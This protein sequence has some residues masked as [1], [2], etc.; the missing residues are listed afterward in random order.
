MIQLLIADDHQVLLDGFVSIF[1]AVDQIKVVDTATNGREVLEKLHG[2]EV[3]IA[4]LDINM[5]ELNGVETCK[6]ISRR[7]ADTKVIALSMYDNP[8]YVKR[9]IKHGAMGY[10]LKND[11]AQEIIKAIETV[12]EGERY[13][14][15]QLKNILNSFEPEHRTHYEAQISSRE[16][17]VLQLIAEGFTDQQI[18]DQLFISIHTVNSHRKKLLLKFD[19]RNTA[20]LVKKTLEKGIIWIIPFYGDSDWYHFRGMFG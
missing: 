3:D 6:Q 17:E 11:T 2:T 12:H 8:S 15:S 7:Y 9:M 13:F 16:L 10:L 4:L 18:A 20:E 1:D 5:P 14:S 19:A